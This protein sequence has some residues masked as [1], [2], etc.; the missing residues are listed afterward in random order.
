VTDSRF[1]V[2]VLDGLR[3]DLVTEESMPNLAAFKKRS[4]VLAG[5]RAQFPT[6]TRV[7]KTTFSTGTTPKHHGILY[8]RILDTKLSDLIIDLGIRTDVQDADSRGRL[9]T[10][11]PIG[12]VLAEAD[13]K[14][15]LVHCGLSGA[16]WLLNYRGNQYGQEHLSM[17]GYDH[18]TP[19]IAKL[20]AKQ[21]GEMPNP[22]GID[23]A[24]SRFAFDAFK[25]VV[26]PQFKPQVGLVWSD[27]PD[28]SLH[29]DGLRGPV[30]RAALA[31]VDAL[32]ADVVQW[33]QTLSESD[34]LNL[35]ILSD[36]GHVEKSQTLPV[37]QLMQR[38]GL[39]VTIDPSE[40]GALLLPFGSGAIYQRNVSDQTMGVI[41]E[42]MQQQSWCGNLFSNDRDGLNGKLP[43]TFSK[44]LASVDHARSPELMFTMRRMNA[45]PPDHAF[46]HCVD[47][48]KPVGSTHGGLHEEETSNIC[49]AAGP[50]FKSRYISQMIGGIADISPTILHILGI[51]KPDTMCGRVLTDLLAEGSAQ[52][53]DCPQCETV[54]VSEGNYHQILSLH[55]L[56]GRNLLASGGRL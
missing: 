37:P 54:S 12:Q 25:T 38:A 17:A 21:M 8:N 48:G 55:R 7:N 46:G 32:V 36:H 45:Q 33:W 9:I 40:D 6:H 41:V 52:Q 15:A 26:Y 23:H 44:A 51:E 18:S 28:K 34:D 22:A 35:I 2:L 42:W 39:P 49:F 10:A 1:F 47:M 16:P 14:F 30:T 20:V 29:I 50:D 53:G 27:E 43:G 4:A 13:R 19:E 56:S 3:P 5:S 24:R 11:T 31:H